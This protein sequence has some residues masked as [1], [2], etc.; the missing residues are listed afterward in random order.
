MG[1]VCKCDLVDLFL[2]DVLVFVVK[3]VAKSPERSCCFAFGGLQL[4]PGVLAE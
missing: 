3:G 4:E 1:A 2:K